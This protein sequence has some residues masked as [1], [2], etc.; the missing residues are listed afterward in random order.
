M[1]TV[2]RGNVPPTHPSVWIGLALASLGLLL[3]IFSY[4]GS[5]V[6]DILFA[7]V[8]LAGGLLAL[9]GI[10]VAAFGRAFMA[11]RASRARRAVFS[12]DAMAAARPAPEPTAED[13][14]TVA[15][16]REKKRFSFPKRKGKE[17]EAQDASAGIFAFQ[18]REPERAPEPEPAPSPSLPPPPSLEPDAPPVALAPDAPPAE[19]VRVTLRCPQCSA[20]FTAEGVRP[21]AATCSSCGFSATV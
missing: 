2:K 4:T 9:V 19:P 17:A 3:A 10:L 6:Y 18:R 14:P 20:T 1:A 15:A 12:A 8:A 21:I 7:I 16:P 13:A 11:S 5:R